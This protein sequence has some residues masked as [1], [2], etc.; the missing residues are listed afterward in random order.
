MRVILSASFCTIERDAEGRKVSRSHM[1]FQDEITKE[2][3]E[4]ASA[5]EL[6]E[7]MGKLY[8]ATMAAHPARSFFV[9]AIKEPR[10]KGRA[11]KGFNGREWDLECDAGGD[12]TRIFNQPIPA[13]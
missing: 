6:G 9:Y 7:R 4:V 11:F 3:A 8:A 12:K 5:A 10:S 1:L 2:T 13:C